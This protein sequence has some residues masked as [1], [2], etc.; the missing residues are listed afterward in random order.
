MAAAERAEEDGECLGG[1]VGAVV[2][3]EG[4]KGVGWSLSACGGW[5]CI[6]SLWET[7]VGIS[8][9]CDG[10]EQD[11]SP[12]GKCLLWSPSPQSFV[13]PFPSPPW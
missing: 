2:A 8:Y 4:S 9:G 11:R 3:L 6:H 13:W 7:A 12:E 5:A 10:E 1:C